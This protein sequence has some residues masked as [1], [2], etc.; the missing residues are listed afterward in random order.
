MS[1]SAAGRRARFGALTGVLLLAATA[2]LVV[3]NVLATRFSARFDAT[4]TREHQISPRSAGLLGRLR[5]D[6]EIVIAA[7]TRDARMV[8]AQALRS[9]RD[10][11]DQL[12]RSVSR[13]ARITSTIIDTGSPEGVDAFEKLLA[14]LVD[15]DR[16]KIKAQGT[17]LLW[18]HIPLG[19][20]LFGYA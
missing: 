16:A 19:V 7:P 18:I 4:S 2:S 1:A 11:L 9:A 20:A 13:E 15:R 8:D 5:G 6:Y 14:R 10:V 12:S 17:N 3:A